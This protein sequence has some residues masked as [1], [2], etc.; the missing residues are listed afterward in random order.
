MYFTVEK[1]LSQFCASVHF[2][3]LCYLDAV[4][5]EG[6]KIRVESNWYLYLYTL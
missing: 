5:L 4:Q 6:Q 2:H 3:L 1:L